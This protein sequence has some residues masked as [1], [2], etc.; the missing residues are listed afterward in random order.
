[1][2][3]SAKM[4]R[5]ARTSTAT[6]RMPRSLPPWPR[7]SSTSCGNRTADTARH[8]PL[9]T[10]SPEEVKTLAG[11]QDYAINQAK[12]QVK[13][14]QKYR[15]QCARAQVGTP[16][17]DNLANAERALDAANRNLNQVEAANRY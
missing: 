2:S 15:D 5:K 12:Q 8:L 14:A 7:R 13:E 1:M 4:H 3:K 9:T 11:N 16:D 17:G 10:D 6:W